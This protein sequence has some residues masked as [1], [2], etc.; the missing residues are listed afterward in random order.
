VI[1]T[2]AT[3]KV[4]CSLQPVA[5]DDER[6]RHPA[7]GAHGVQVCCNTLH[8]FPAS[9]DSQLDSYLRTRHTV[10]FNCASPHL[11][12][13]NS[14]TSWAPHLNSHLSI[15]I[16]ELD[17]T[18]TLTFQLSPITAAHLSALTFQLAGWRGSGP[19]TNT[20]KPL[21]APEPRG[22]SRNCR[23]GQVKICSL[24]LPLHVSPSFAEFNSVSA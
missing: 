18:S 8:A 13:V 16:Y 15:L 5:G 17:L 21:T 1:S 14:R 2:R 20:S 7:G 9:L 19:G 10:Y 4:T 22:C 3:T 11:L 6:I 12:P 24:R 23:S